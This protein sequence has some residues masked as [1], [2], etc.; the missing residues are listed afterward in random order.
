MLDAE[1]D[2]E[3]LSI[4]HDST[5]GDILCYIYSDN[6]LLDA[7]TL[8]EDLY[9]PAVTTLPSAPDQVIQ[10]IAKD[11]L[12]SQPIGTVQ[13]RLSLLLESTESVALPMNTPLVETLPAEPA[14][15]FIRL[16]WYAKEAL[17]RKD[18][19]LSSFKTEENDS[20][21]AMQS[22]LEIEK[23]KNKGLKQL[24]EEMNV[25]EIARVSAMQKLQRVAEEYEEEI[26]RLKKEVGS[27]EGGEKE[28]EEEE[29]FKKVCEW[30][31][32]EKEYIGSI[33]Q[34]EEEKQGMDLEISNDAED[35]KN[36]E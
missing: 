9:E 22:E 2:V 6:N 5:Q 29:Y 30:R 1:L 35:G 7:V 24:R 28:R 31:D 34:L 11:L 3:I 10:I 15:P 27:A 23:W 4:V 13:F 8:T 21:R 32:R 33:L 19:S 12:R 17:G 36:E 26:R 20:I 16:K 18:D 25:S 14:K